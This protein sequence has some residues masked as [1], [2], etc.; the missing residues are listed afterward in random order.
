MIDEDSKIAPRKP[1]VFI[2]HATADTYVAKSMRKDIKTTGAE[3]FLDAIDVEIGDEIG[4]RIQKGLD[5]CTELVVL[6]TPQSIHRRWV[7]IE[8]GAAWSQKKR[9]AG[10]V[11]GMTTAELL[12]EPDMPIV[13]KERNLTHLN[14]FSKYVGQLRARVKRSA[15]I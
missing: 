9:V 11:H 2:S 6:L 3:S 10:V 1:V 13:I 8:I 15:G 12:N 4:P 14:N 5:R 7:W